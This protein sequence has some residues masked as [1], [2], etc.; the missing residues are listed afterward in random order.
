MLDGKA[1]V[2]TGAGRG[3]GAAYAEDCARHGASVVVND[4]DLDVAEE[5]TAAIVDA[6][7]TAVTEQADIRVSKDAGRLID[8]CVQE[9]GRIDGLVNNAGVFRM[10]LLDEQDED[11]LRELVETNIV[12]T[13]LCASAAAKRMKAQGSGSIVNITSGAHAGIPMMGAYGATKGAAASAVYAWAQELA[14]T[15][16]RVNA[17]SPQGRTRMSDITA[18][19]LVSH[20]L[21]LYPGTQ[22][23]AE[24]NTP[25]V[26]F[27]LS[28]A[29][30]DVTGQV[31][32]IEGSQLALMSH[33][34]VLLPFPTRENGWTAEEVQAAFA[35]DLA[36]RQQPLGIHGLVG[37]IKG[38]SSVFWSDDE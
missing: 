8:R 6:G 19:F 9:F 18:D 15:G 24:A 4:L 22:P 34:C 14:G 25:A 37:E 23:E 35:T 5:V 28:D 38:I 30:A 3:I 20:G 10:G 1:V 17:V 33:P 32:R 31:V 26:V 11:E 36:A 16:V 12:G 2:I 13:F 7:G 21:P 27:L 29:A